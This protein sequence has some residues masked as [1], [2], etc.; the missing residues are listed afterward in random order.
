[1][2]TIRS[3]RGAPAAFTL[4]EVLVVVAIIALLVAIMLPSL[5]K[6]REQ[7]KRTSCKANL[8]S[9]GHGMAF[10][11]SDS[12]GILPAARIY[13]VGG[14]QRMQDFYYA[15]LGAMIPNGS[16]P[17]NR[18]LKNIDVFR[19][20][21]DA[22]DPVISAASFFEAH[23][24]SYAYASHA[25]VNGT[26]LPDGTTVTDEIPDPYQLPP[27]YGVQSCR[28]HPHDPSRDGLP[29]GF[30]KR[31]A[32]K[33]VFLE[34]PLNPA[35]ANPSSLA[36]GYPEDIPTY[37]SVFKGNSQA[38]WHSK[39]RQHANVL[40][41]DFHVEFVYFNEEQLNATVLGPGA[42]PWDPGDAK[43]RYY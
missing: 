13:G 36:A 20:P 10:Y 11:L 9:I 26:P 14:Y 6:A 24:T 12:N 32:N 1:M 41:A 16:R 31:P 28:A 35:F 21:S 38:Q 4:I 34:P 18:Y 30:V 42:T 7:A 19:C 40:F 2:G 39:E 15:P 8:R 25:K 33:I 37:R 3:R 43:R 17:L 23:G 29:M 5:S 22:G 27:P